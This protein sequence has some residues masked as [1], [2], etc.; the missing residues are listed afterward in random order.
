MTMISS[1]NHRT[2]MNTAKA[3]ARKF[4]KVKPS[5]K[6]REEWAANKAAIAASGKTQRVFVAATTPA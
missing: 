3:S 2:N 6:S 1:Q 4:R 5:A